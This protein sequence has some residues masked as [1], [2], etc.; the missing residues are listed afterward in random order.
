VKSGIRRLRNQAATKP[1]VPLA[2]NYRRGLAFDLGV[3]RA[4]RE[5]MM[6]A[7]GM[8]GTVFSIVSLLQQAP[9][10]PK[11]HLYKKQPKDGRVRYTTGD[12]G[13]DQRVEVIRHPALSLWN[14]PNS[15]HSGFE[16]REGCNQHLELTG[17]TIWVAG[18]EVVNF[19]TSL[20]YVRPDRME[21]VPSPDDYLVGWI[22]TGP[23]GEQ[24]PLNL[25]EVIIEKMPDPLDPFRG[26]GPVASIMPNIQQ[27]KYA[28]DYQRNLF[29]N[30][31]DPGGVITVPNRLSD[32]EWD[33]FTDR[34]RESHQGVARAGR[35]GI[36]ENGATW[37]NAGLSNK[38]M[39]YGEL[40]L[41][42]RDELREGWRI[43]KSMLGTADDVNRA[44]AQTAQE[45][46]VAWQTIP[47]LE[48]RKDTLNCKLLPMFGDATTEFDYEDPSP[49]N[50]EA[51]NAEMLA[52]AQSA[53][54]LV[55][56]GYDPHDVLE[57]I[58]LPDMGVLE[59]ATQ[60]PA[61]PPAW[62]PEDPASGGGDTA[63]LDREVVNLILDATRKRKPVPQLQ[64]AKAWMTDGPNAC[65]ACRANAAQGPIPVG[66]NFTS[67]AAEPPQHPNCECRLRDTAM[68][69]DDD[70][71]ALLRRVL[72]DGLMPVQMSRS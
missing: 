1:P 72:S 21:P 2:T 27:Q 51:A 25:D 55:N 57:V 36:L 31:A 24:V 60:A 12:Q 59:K 3:G 19:P 18:R 5:T 68:R 11:W 41:A 33:E 26:A 13:S 14:S 47:R 35:V 23:S 30:G 7:Y 52:K 15:F 39:E 49:T 10:T 42:N 58:G 17:E 71:A 45:V 37:T 65:E 44:N 64:P 16:F 48:R 50:P 54:A 38:D 20:W 61:L 4:S 43:H 8:S 69:H 67:G 9:A 28:T 32:K 6:R 66:D 34:W 40:R 63:N 70:Y 29:I 46:F 62:V 22:Y 53:Q 56:A